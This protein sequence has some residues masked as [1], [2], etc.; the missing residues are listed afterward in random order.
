M[1]SSSCDT[2]LYGRY[3]ASTNVLGYGAIGY[4]VSAYDYE[5]TDTIAIKIIRKSKDTSSIF[6]NE[7]KCMISANRIPHAHI[8]KYH[9]SFSD[10]D[11]YYIAM[12]RYEGDDLFDVVISNGRFSESETATAMRALFN[13]V[14]HL[15]TQNI[16]HRDLKPEN[17][18]VRFGQKSQLIGLKVIDFGVA[19]SN[20][21]SPYSFDK[22]G[23]PLYLAPE[24]INNNRYYD[25]TDIWSCGV[26]MY[27]LLCSVPPFNGYGQ[28][29]DNPPMFS[30]ACWK[31]VHLNARHLI[32]LLLDKQYLSR[33]SL[34][35]ALEH[36]WFRTTKWNTLTTQ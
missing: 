3:K 29:K 32:R 12:E 21:T 11:Y 30:D 18:L 16:L 8:I 17:I 19:I 25:K 15:H 6:E 28:I 13:A 24:V 1:Y 9:Q 14:A 27:I 4:V 35:D 36:E 20:K 26:I 33:I 34:R 2:L 5:T 10:D 31:T 7:V 22:V 23:S